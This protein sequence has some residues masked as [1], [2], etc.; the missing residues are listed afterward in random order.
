M[1]QAGN[2]LVA[3]G[4]GN[5]TWRG[6]TWRCAV[7]RG[8]ADHHIEGDGMSPLGSFPLREL[9]YRAD[10]LDPPKCFLKAEPISTAMLW[11][12]GDSDAEYYNRLVM[13][14]FGGSHEQL[15]RED[16]VYDIIVPLGY[17]DDPPVP[18]RGS[19]IFLHVAREAFTPTNGCIALALPD[20]LKFL[21]E[22]DAETLVRIVE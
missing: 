22:A 5:A 9:F 4:N 17:N 3:S 18:G 19:A 15:Y 20:L 6:R 14:P 11:A 2:I 7:G 1:T 8:V 10:R 12:D 21:A 16:H 13:A